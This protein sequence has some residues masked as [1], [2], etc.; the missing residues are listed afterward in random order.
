MENKSDDKN[1]FCN[2][3]F[4][5]LKERQFNIIYG[6]FQYK[7]SCSKTNENSI[8]FKLIKDKDFQDNYYELNF[9]INL[10]TKLSDLF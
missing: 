3:N 5:I 8:F 2:C 10:L 6:E 1:S 4:E 7:L 9:K